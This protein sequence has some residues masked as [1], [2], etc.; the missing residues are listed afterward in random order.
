MMIV[1]CPLR[2]RDWILPQW[3]EHVLT[4]L[5]V[6]GIN[7]EVEF[8]FVMGEDDEAPDW[9]SVITVE[10]PPRE[11]VRHWDVLR[12]EH[13]TMLRNT[14]LA[15]VRERA[16]KYFLSLDSDILLHPEAAAGMLEVFRDH[17]SAWAV[18]GKTFM[19][20]GCDAPSYG[21]WYNKGEP[22]LGIK[23]INAE[24]VLQVDVIMAIKMMAEPAYLTDYVFHPWGEDVGWSSNVTQQGGDLFWDGRY[25]SK[26]VMS[27]DRLERVDARC[28]Y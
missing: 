9:A 17:P 21:N 26:H 27:R 22:R 7:T 5:E 14:L 1:G 28:G 8:L 11:D 12:F 10:E 20:G 23:R 24:Q 13:M 3:R 25:C 2:K 18:G 6:A 16:P 15:G 19:S 4:S